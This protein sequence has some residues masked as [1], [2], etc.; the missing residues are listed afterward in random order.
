MAIAWKGS[1][2]FIWLSAKKM[3]SKPS[4]SARFARVIA[5]SIVRAEPCK[6]KFITMIISP[7]D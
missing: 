6:Q 7:F 5:S 1:T 4:S 2:L 3:A